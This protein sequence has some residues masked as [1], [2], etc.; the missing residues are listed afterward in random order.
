MECPVCKADVD[1]ELVR[2]IDEGT[3]LQVVCD[4]CGGVYVHDLNPE[5]WRKKYP[6]GE[7]Q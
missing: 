5:K 6:T 3:L 4:W 7:N 1:D 2:V